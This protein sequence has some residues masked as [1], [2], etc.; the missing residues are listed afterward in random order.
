MNAENWGFLAYSLSLGALECIDDV[1]LHSVLLHQASAA[2]IL[3]DQGG[4]EE[5]FPGLEAMADVRLDAAGTVI[6]VV[7]I[8]DAIDAIAQEV[9]RVAEL[10]EVALATAE[11]IVFTK[12]P[13]RCGFCGK[14]VDETR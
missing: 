12:L 11:A 14:C 2:R 7:Q 9:A 13:D 1:P 4:V 6:T 5:G 8:D 3:K 10:S